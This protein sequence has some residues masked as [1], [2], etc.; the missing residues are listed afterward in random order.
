M[1]NIKLTK[2]DKVEIIW[3]DTNVPQDSKWMSETEHLEWTKQ[4]GSLVQSIGVY[5]TEDEKFISLVGD[6]DGD[7]VTEKYLLRAISINKGCIKEI[8]KLKRIGGAK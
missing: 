3:N 5:I 6:L 1:K 4:G 7:D 8:Y 2:G